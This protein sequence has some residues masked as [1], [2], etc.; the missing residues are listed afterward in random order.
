MTKLYELC[1]ELHM[2]LGDVS[3]SQ[4]SRELSLI[5]KVLQCIYSRM[6]MKHRHAEL[7]AIRVSSRGYSD[8]V[9]VS[10]KQV[11]NLSLPRR[12][13]ENGGGQHVISE[14][15]FILYCMG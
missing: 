3:C 10:I 13:A 7:Y 8:Q 14:L 1:L 6:Q 11:K 12:C 15:S 4:D 9:M 5:S 2:N